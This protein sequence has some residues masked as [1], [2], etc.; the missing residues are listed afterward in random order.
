MTEEQLERLKVRLV[1][2]GVRPL[3]RAKWEREGSDAAKRAGTADGRAIV[4]DCVRIV[5]AK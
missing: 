5:R 4:G 1:R 2:L 3:T